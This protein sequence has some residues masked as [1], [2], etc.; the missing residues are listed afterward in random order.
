MVHS[1]THGS[2]CRYKPGNG[3]HV[4]AAHTDSPCP[5]LR[6]VSYS[7]KGGF[8]HV[9]VQPYGTGVWQTWFDRDLSIAGRVLLRRKDGVLV[10]ELVRVRRPILRIP[11]LAKPL[12]RC[13]CLHSVTYLPSFFNYSIRH[14]HFLDKNLTSTATNNS[15]V[16]IVLVVMLIILLT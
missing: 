12:D 14:R 4:L 16:F 7:A 10:H 8:L 6:P 15:E 11:T 9:R 1:D 13:A 5:K 3:F 2:L